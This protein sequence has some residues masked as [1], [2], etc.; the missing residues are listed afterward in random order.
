MAFSILF[1]SGSTRRA[2]RRVMYLASFVCGVLGPVAAHAGTIVTAFD[3]QA[4]VS[5]LQDYGGAL[6]LDFQVS[7]TT[8]VSALGVYDDGIAA[9]LNGQDGVSGVTVGI[10][11]VNTGMLVGSTV[12]FT[13]GGIGSYTVLNGDAFQTLATAITLA[14][15]TYSIVAFNDDN[16]NSQGGTNTT[17]TANSEGPV[18]ITGGWRYDSSTALALPGGTGS[19]TTPRFDAGTFQYEVPEPASL[20]MLAGALGALATMRRRRA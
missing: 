1:T 19:N 3:N 7:A 13:A 4:N 2:A 11:N 16:Y 18:T 6:G 10:F 14:P 9:D 15:G 8:T 20:A 5:G 17:T 12:T